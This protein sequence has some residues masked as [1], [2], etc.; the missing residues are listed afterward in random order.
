MVTP[1][2]SS[3][4]GNSYN[5]ASLS[6]EQHNALSALPEH[7][8]PFF[9]VHRAMHAIKASYFGEKQIP[10]EAFYL[11]GECGAF[12]RCAAMA[13]RRLF[14]V[15]PQDLALIQL[16]TVIHGNALDGSTIQSG[17]RPKTDGNHVILY[18]RNGLR[19]LP[20]SGEGD[21]FFDSTAAQFPNARDG[22]RTE[23]VFEYLR[24]HG[25]RDGVLMAEVLRQRGYIKIPAGTAGKQ[26]LGVLVAAYHAKREWNPTP[27][28]IDPNELYGRVANETLQN[29]DWNRFDQIVQDKPHR[30]TEWDSDLLF[31]VNVPFGQLNLDHPKFAITYPSEWHSLDF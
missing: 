1:S 7:K 22:D 21:V 28:P 9:A 20:N 11:A 29:W 18:I 2:S 27:E 8:D 12:S 6:R 10:L 17:F 13:L 5:R 25:G 30:R 3:H 14:H 19:L 26:R 15:C 31:D 4:R 23:N 16:A 24:C